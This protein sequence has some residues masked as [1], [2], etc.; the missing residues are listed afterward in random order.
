MR[1][2]IMQPY[3]FPYIGYWQ[4]IH[5]VDKFI[6]YDNIK[7]TKKGWVNRNRF[8]QNGK[9][10]VFSVP[11]KKDS[12]Y[13]DVR[14]RVISS[15]FNKIKLL[16]QLK[17]AYKSAPYYEQTMEFIEQVI[18]Y[19]EVNLFLYLYNSIIMVCEQFGITTEIMISSTITIDHGSKKQD[20]VI[21]LCEAVGAD[22]YVN[23]I[24]GMELYSK[25]AFQGNGIDLRFI[26]SK[27]FVYQQFG[28]E[29]IQWLSIID[30]M[31][32]NSVD[33]IKACIT[34]NYELNNV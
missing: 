7:Y 32:F 4:L 30:V 20:K 6:I 8:L 12:D 15:D 25:E 31:M 14:E 26:Q 28:N 19:D 18:K 9:G 13:L 1:V 27:S 34:N 29:F 33:E 16:N 24:G 21:A 10:I 11:L 17:G 2:A 23:V 22:V 5:S 3:L